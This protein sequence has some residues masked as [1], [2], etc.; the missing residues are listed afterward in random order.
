MY[1]ALTT[2]VLLRGY[3]RKHFFVFVGCLV[4]K[5]KKMEARVN[6]LPMKVTNDDV[7]S[8]TKHPPMNK[9]PE[10]SVHSCDCMQYISEQVRTLAGLIESIKPELQR[11]I[12]NS[13]EMQKTQLM[14]H[15]TMQQRHK[16]T[17]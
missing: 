10:C 3:L 17:R 15:W 13:M 2:P 5:D 1:T 7:R 8:P 11:E 6:H 16:Q 14:A 4:D 12:A 9:M